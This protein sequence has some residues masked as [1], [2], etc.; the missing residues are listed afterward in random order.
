[1]YSV[2][3]TTSAY[4]KRTT[5]YTEYT[6]EPGSGLPSSCGYAVL[7]LFLTQK[8]KARAV[9]R[10]TAFYVFG[11]FRGLICLSSGKKAIFVLDIADID[12]I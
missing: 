5:E 9:N 2:V 12:D 11:V 7:D 10:N 4:R 3:D 1:V 8:A 6:E